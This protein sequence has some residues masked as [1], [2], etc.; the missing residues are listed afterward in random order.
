[1]RSEEILGEYPDLEWEEIL[2][3]HVDAARLARMKR[4]VPPA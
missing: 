4:T 3:V 1:M 2:A